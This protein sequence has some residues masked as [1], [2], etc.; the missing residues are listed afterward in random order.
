MNQQLLSRFTTIKIKQGLALKRKSE[1][2]EKV[3]S[4]LEYQTALS[5]VQAKLQVLA[6]NTQNQL[7][8]RIVDI[9]QSCLDV[10]FPDE[11]KFIFEFVQKRG[12]T[13]VDMY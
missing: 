13:E 1:L 12:K 4:L 9:V 10:V 2:T 6:Q 5:E 3:N 7:Q 8:Q 11:Y